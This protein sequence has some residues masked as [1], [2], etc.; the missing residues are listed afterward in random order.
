MCCDTHSVKDVQDLRRWMTDAGICF[1]AEDHLSP[2]EYAYN[3]RELI[4]ALLD[5]LD[6]A[7]DHGEK[8]NKHLQDLEKANREACCAFC[9]QRLAEDAFW[10]GEARTN[11]L[12]EHIKTCPK[13]PLRAAE[14]KCAQLR[15]ALVEVQWCRDGKCP[16]CGMTPYCG[17]EQWCVIGKVMRSES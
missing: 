13:H 9:G 15:E 7:R 8:A 12:A 2:E 3:L 6:A 17:H 11:A 14:A 4:V 5:Q 16:R 1:Q 10:L